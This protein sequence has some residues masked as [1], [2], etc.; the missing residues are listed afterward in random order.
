VRLGIA[1]NA[2][3]GNWL[4]AQTHRPRGRLWTRRKVPLQDLRCHPDLC[5]RLDELAHGLP[6]VRVRYVG[7]LPILV[8][9][10][11]VVFAVGGG[12]T[13]SALRLPPRVHTAIIRSEWGL[14]GLEG[15]WIDV[16]PWLSDI[17]RHDGLRRLRGWSRAAYDHAA[18]LAPMRAP[19]PR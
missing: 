19:A 4:R 3:I 13:W 12:T 9:P 15:E 14:R 8:H 2:D 6:G 7:G 10:G 18:E 11:G 16:D 1:A 5:E 17:P